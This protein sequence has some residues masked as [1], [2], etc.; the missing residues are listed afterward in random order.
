[1]STAP[2]GIFPVIEEMDD[3]FF[4]SHLFKYH[5]H[6][7]EL[8]PFGLISAYIKH[9]SIH[10]DEESDHTHLDGHSYFLLGYEWPEIIGG[11]F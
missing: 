5:R 1:M 6:D 11:K 7:V 10:Q 8:K 3:D 9:K 4:L 2:E